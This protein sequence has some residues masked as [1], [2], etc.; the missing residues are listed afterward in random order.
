MPPRKCCCGTCFIAED[1][2]NRADSADP[3]PLWYTVDGAEIV[4]NELLVTARTSLIPCSSFPKG[5]IAASFKIVNA[6]TV[7]THVIR[8]GDPAGSLEVEVFFAGTFGVDGT[9]TITISGA[10]EAVDYTFPWEVADETIRICYV[11]DIQISA[12]P[13]VGRINASAHP[14]WV[15]S[16]LNVA[17]DD[18]WLIG[19]QSVGNLHFMEGNFDDFVAQVHDDEL[20]GCPDCDCYCEEVIDGIGERFCIPPE[21][22]LNLYSTT[23]GATTGAYAMTQILATDI[24]LETA[25]TLIPWPQKLMWVSEVVTC[26]A[27]ADQKIQFHLRCSAGQ[28]TYPRFLLTMVRWEPSGSSGNLGCSAM[29]FDLDDP[30]TV[31]ATRSQGNGTSEAYATTGTCSPFSLTFPSVIEDQFGCNTNSGSCCGG[32]IESGNGIPGDPCEFGC[33]SAPSIWTVSITE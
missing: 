13:G 2:F 7:A 5:S 25:P 28:F 33:E 16:C 11:P 4:D 23:C 14:D 10:S 27:N 24:N 9:F 19:S 30:D 6:A 29:G 3:G 8:L 18:C 20:D 31:E 17:Y 15:T 21:L 26:S 32:G 1:D 22:T 12:G